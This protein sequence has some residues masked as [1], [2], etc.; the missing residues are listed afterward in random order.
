MVNILALVLCIISF[1]VMIGSG[2]YYRA[3]SQ[4]NN[5]RISQ[6][7]KEARDKFFFWEY[8]P[9][10]VIEAEDN[11]RQAMHSLGMYINGT[12]TVQKA[13]ATS[14][15]VENIRKMMNY[16]SS[17]PYEIMPR[18]PAVSGMGIL[19]VQNA[20]CL[21]ITVTFRNKSVWEL[22]FYKTSEGKWGLDWPAFV[23]LQ[24][25]DWQEFVHGSEDFPGGMEFRV[26]A[27]REKAYEDATHYAVR[28]MG[29]T[30]NGSEKPGVFSPP[31]MVEKQSEI[32][33]K[34]YRMLRINEL[35]NP[36][37]RILNARDDRKHLRLRA[38]ISKETGEGGNDKLFRLKRIVAEGWYD[39]PPE[40]A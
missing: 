33:K 37:Y 13:S 24:P 8:L 2:F 3:R 15:S 20:P 28:F 12:T 31:V 22:D 38:V 36:A 40:Q 5:A 29:A 35:Q 39:D 30:P 27:M 17:R 25:M 11:A 10:P 4:E 7:Q 23:R 19:K 1:F 34:L 9:V 14:N 18:Q 26:W 32:G 21:M 6:E 16:Y